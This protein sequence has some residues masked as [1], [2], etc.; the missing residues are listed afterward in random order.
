M[1]S[2]AD[3][4]ELYIRAKDGNRPHL[5]RCAFADDARLDMI[6][7]AANISFPDHSVGLDSVTEVLVSRFGSLF[8]NVYTFCLS[9]PPD[10][11]Q[12]S[13]SCYWL[14][15]MSGKQDRLVRVGCGRYGWS[16]RSTRP[17]VVD[18][19]RITIA[20]ME[21]RPSNDL[22]AIMDWL[23]RLPYP[24]CPRGAAAGMIPCLDGLESISGFLTAVRPEGDTVT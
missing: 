16:F 20:H 8:E 11:D 2:G 19:L 1:Q 15:G 23:S 21:T 3:C 10:R 13:F 5:M 7:N 12:A 24:W 4:I 17:T 22:P 18:R 14:V 9:Q 6:V